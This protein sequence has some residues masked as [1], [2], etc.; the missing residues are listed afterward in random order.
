[1]EACE[2]GSMFEGQLPDNINVYVTTASNAVESS[3]GTY[4][5]PDDFVNGVELNTCLGDLYSVN[6]MQDS[7]RSGAMSETLEQQYLVVQAET[8]LSHVMQYGDLSF[9]SSDIGNFLA[10]WQLQTEGAEPLE[11]TGSVNQANRRYDHHHESGDDS[12]EER[13]SRH[14]QWRTQR[15]N[16]SS[17]RSRD[18][19][20][21]LSYYQYLRSAESSFE[22]RMKLVNELQEQLTKRVNSDNMFMQLARKFGNGDELYYNKGNMCTDA[23]CGTVYQSFY[24]KC[25]GFDDYSMQYGRVIAN[26]CAIGQD[27]AVISD[28]LN[29]LC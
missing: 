8:T 9:T 21:H 29:S 13:H 6:W 26:I 18:I 1:M 23:C 11:H 28:Y 4:C 19:P 27:A 7:D 20:M 16:R 24:D 2:A 5:P 22:E 3:W 10:N 25:G 15:K 12:T 14:H 17:V